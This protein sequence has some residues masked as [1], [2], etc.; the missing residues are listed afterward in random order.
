MR[1]ERVFWGGGGKGKDVV[2]IGVLWVRF[3][4]LGGRARCG[5]LVWSAVAMASSCFRH[6]LMIQTELVAGSEV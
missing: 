3:G 1:G 2:R 4:W 5:G 6:I